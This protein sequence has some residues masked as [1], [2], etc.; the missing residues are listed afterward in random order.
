MGWEDRQ[1]HQFIIHGE[2]FAI[3]DDAEEHCRNVPRRKE[4][5]VELQSGFATEDLAYYTYDFRDNW[6]H[7]VKVQRRFPDEGKERYPLC[8]EGAGHCPPEGCGGKYEFARLREAI[9]DPEHEDHDLFVAWLGP[10]TE[11]EGRRIAAR[12]GLPPPLAFDP[13]AFTV[14]EVNERLSPI[15][16][17]RKV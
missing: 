1:P 16:R 14:D 17:E 7:E 4:R 15:R 3:P 10:Q 9:R 8:L 13:D 12:Y 5:E 11:T 6:I 2:T